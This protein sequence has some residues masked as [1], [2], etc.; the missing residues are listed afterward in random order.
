MKTPV[1]EACKFTKK[2]LW[3]RCFPVN[4]MK[5]LTT[6]F[7]QNT[8]RRLLLSFFHVAKLR[9]TYFIILCVLIQLFFDPDGMYLFKVKNKDTRTTGLRPATLL[10][11]RLWH[12]CFPVNFLEHLFLAENLQ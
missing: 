10:K 1:L 2:R 4:F 11:K 3:R 7:L 12:R 5:F 9:K 8:S 6:H